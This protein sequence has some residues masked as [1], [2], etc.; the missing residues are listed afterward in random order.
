MS[1]PGSGNSWLRY[2][3]EGI[4]GI[5]TGS[6]FDDEDLIRAGLLGEGTGYRRQ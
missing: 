1:H 6:I 5:F 2:L 4:S 3:L